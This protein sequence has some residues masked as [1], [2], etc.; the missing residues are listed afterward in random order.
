MDTTF[1]NL[2]RNPAD[3]QRVFLAVNSAILNSFEQDKARSPLVFIVTEHEVRR[4]FKICEKWFRVMRGDCGYSVDR[5]VDFVPLALRTELDGGT[6]EPP[7][8]EGGW[9]PSVLKRDIPA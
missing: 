6:F 4:R 9:A 5:A 3:L 2:V 8:G 7:K 1:G